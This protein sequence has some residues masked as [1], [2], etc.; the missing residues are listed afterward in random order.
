MG[1]V[2]SKLRNSARGQP[3]TLAIPGICSHDPEQ[4]VLCHLPSEVKGTGNKSDDF[5]SVLGCSSC[6]I[7]LDNHRLNRE[8]E[9]YY[10]LRALAR[11]WRFWVTSGLILVPQD[12]HRAKPSSKILPRRHLATGETL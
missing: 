7:H 8:D 6:H 5:F 4:T 9:L 3:C 10:S 12:T 11:T 1:I 2:S